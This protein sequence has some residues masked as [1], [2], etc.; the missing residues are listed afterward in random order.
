MWVKARSP[1]LENFQGSESSQICTYAL[2]KIAE[3]LGKSFFPGHP[4]KS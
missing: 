3:C 2:R 1:I 4:N